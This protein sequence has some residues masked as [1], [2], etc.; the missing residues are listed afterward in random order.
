[1][2]FP[3]IVVRSTEGNF[4]FPEVCVISEETEVRDKTKKAMMLTESRE[5]ETFF[6]M[7]TLNYLL[8][9]SSNTRP[10]NSKKPNLLN[11]IDAKVKIYK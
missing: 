6:M 11:T 1:M 4:L 10:I 7:I 2:G 9:S 8:I 5:I 3:S